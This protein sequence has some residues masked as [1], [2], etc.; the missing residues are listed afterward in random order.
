MN[1]ERQTDDIRRDQE[2]LD[3]FSTPSPDGL[4]MERIKFVVRQEC[5]GRPVASEGDISAAI[6][7]AKAAVRRSLARDS[8]TQPPVF[9]PWAPIMVTA[10]AVAFAFLSILESSTTNAVTDPELARF[11]DVMSRPAEDTAL[12]L[13]DIENDLS[14][15]VT[16]VHQ[17]GAAEWNAPLLLEVGDAIGRYGV[18]TDVWKDDL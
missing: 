1:T 2:W 16:D 10:A 3:R 13:M 4:A 6:H 14:D 18:D 9:K 17:N 12:A 15:L 8:A 5:T 11:I 7:A